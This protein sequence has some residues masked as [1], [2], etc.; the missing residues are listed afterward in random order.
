VETFSKQ[1][2]ELSDYALTIN[3]LKN[4]Y[5]EEDLFNASL[6]FFEVFSSIMFDHHQDKL[7][8]SQLE[9][10]FKEAGISIHQTVYLFTGVDLKDID[11]GEKKFK[12]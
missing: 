6:V 9:V 8:Q 10:L 12:V 2:S 11:F 4:K 3:G 5:N 7:N 1:L